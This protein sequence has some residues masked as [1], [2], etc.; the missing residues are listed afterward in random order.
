[1]FA[2]VSLEKLERLMKCNHWRHFRETS[3]KKGLPSLMDS[4]FKDALVR[5][6][7]RD[8]DPKVWVHRV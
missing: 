5:R 7:A 6:A 1:M 2:F 8:L 4:G 3:F